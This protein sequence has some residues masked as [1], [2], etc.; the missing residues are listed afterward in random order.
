MKILSFITSECLAC[1]MWWHQR[2]WVCCSVPEFCS[3]SPRAPPS[4]QDL[5]R[6][7]HS[8]K[9]PLTL[10]GFSSTPACIVWL[11]FRSSPS[12]IS[13]L[14]FVPLHLV[15]FPLVS[16]PLYL[17]MFGLVSVP[18][19]LVLVPLVP[20]P[21][22][23]VMFGLVSVPLHLVLVAW[24]SFLSILYWSLGFRSSPSCIGPLGSRSSPYCIVCL[25]HN[26]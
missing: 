16:V 2:W 10:L 19:H 25:S 21:L 26:K 8:A 11:C 14:V 12:C 6:V 9:S 1:N 20:V 17:V 7:S 4:C 5:A 3:P 15:L 18:L 22:Y 24:F 13:R 23:L